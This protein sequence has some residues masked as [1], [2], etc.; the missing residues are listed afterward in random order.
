MSSTALLA[1]ANSAFGLSQEA[2]ASTSAAMSAA[3]WHTN[4]RFS[5]KAHAYATTAPAAKLVAKYAYAKHFAGSGSW[6]QID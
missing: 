3:N 4:T 1:P 5:T 6:S 2:V